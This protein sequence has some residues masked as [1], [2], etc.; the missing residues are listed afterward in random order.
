MTLTIIRSKDLDSLYYGLCFNARQNAHVRD[1]CMTP[2]ELVT[3]VAHA[4]HR[5]YKPQRGADKATRL[6]QVQ[7]GNE[8]YRLHCKV[9]V[10]YGEADELG[11][12]A[13]VG[14]YAVLDGELLALHCIVKGHGDWL[15]QHAKSDGAR[16]LQCWDTQFL[17]NFYERHGFKVVATEP[18]NNGDPRSVITMELPK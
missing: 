6:E 4:Y 11:Q 16:K 13:R 2:G 3:E 18:S 12:P 5:R 10:V 1:S 17:R 14:G 7:R 8:F 9:N 15:M